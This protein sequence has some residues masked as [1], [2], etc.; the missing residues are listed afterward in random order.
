MKEDVSAPPSEGVYIHGLFIEGA[1]WDRK[2]VRLTESAPKVIYQPMPVIHVS[3]TNSND[4]GDPRMYRCPVYKRPKRTD[5]NYIFDVD[6]KT[7]QPP[8]Y[9]IMRGV[10]MLGATS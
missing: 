2:N 8:E 1:A 3:A 7:Q 4:D 10:A 9:W 5:L 6:L